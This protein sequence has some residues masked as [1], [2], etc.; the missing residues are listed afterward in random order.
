M[1]KILTFSDGTIYVERPGSRWGRVNVSTDQFLLPDSAMNE[2]AYVPVADA[3]ITTDNKGSTI[4]I[5]L[6]MFDYLDKAHGHSK[7]ASNWM[8][9]PYMLWINRPFVGDTLGSTLADGA[10]PVP[11]TECITCSGNIMRVIGETATHYEVEAYP[12]TS[13]FVNK[14]VPN[15]FNFRNYPWIFWKAQAR[16]REGVLMRVGAGLDVYHM[17][18]R[19]PTNRHYIHKSRLSLFTTTPFDVTKDGHI[20]TVLDYQFIGNEI[21]GITKDGRIPLM[22]KVS[23]LWFYPTSWRGVGMPVV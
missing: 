7:A 11:V 13:D 6:A 2:V 17:H 1:P 22:V 8:R 14:C 20:Y 23:G 12:Y 5:N 21:Y 18:I 19:K 3:P 9:T 15:V 4:R 16:T 10:D